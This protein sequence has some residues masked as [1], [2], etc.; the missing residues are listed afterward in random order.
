MEV[1]WASM[2][3]TVP[4]LAGSENLIVVGVSSAY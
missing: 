3:F 2:I 1:P 4:G